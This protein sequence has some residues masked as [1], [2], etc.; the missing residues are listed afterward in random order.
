MTG[1]H[2][3]TFRQ[4]SRRAASIIYDWVGGIV[5]A[6]LVIALLLTYVFRIVAVDGDSMLPTLEDG[7]RL[8]LTYSYSEFEPGDV[9]V[10]D[11]YAEDPLIKRV[12]AVGGDTVEIVDTHVYVNNVMLQEPYIQGT[13]LPRDITGKVRVPD[14]YV[15]LMGDNRS[16]S[17][18]SR[19]DEIGL[20]SVKDIVGKVEFCV[21]P[22]TS[23]G[24]ID[25]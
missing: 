21:W 11:R 4:K 8:L 10:V 9:V 3:Q 16:V 15:F 17:K 13:T 6:L 7:D 24:K 2:T 23:I 14:G 1:K 12:I 25:S 22:P 19:M 20:I 5:M 18:D